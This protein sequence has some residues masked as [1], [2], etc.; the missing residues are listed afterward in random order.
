MDREPGKEILTVEGLSKTVE[1]VKVLDNVSFRV[2]KGDKIAFVADNELAI[3]T[4]F[5]ILMEELTPDA[6]SFKWGGLHQPELFSPGQLR[7]FRRD[8]EDTIL[9]WL[10]AVLQRHH[11]DLPAGLSGEDALLRGRRATSR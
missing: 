4:L 1:G 7:L 5:K 2:N 8:T 3:T 11:R 9:Q 10:D 6:G